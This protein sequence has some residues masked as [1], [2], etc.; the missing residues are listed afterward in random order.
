MSRLAT[1]EALRQELTALEAAGSIRLDTFEV[2]APA[3]AADYA[4]ASSYAPVPEWLRPL[5]DDCNGLTVRY[6]YVGGAS[7][8]EERYGLEHL[9]G[10]IN[11]LPLEEVFRD[12][13]GSVYFDGDEDAFRW[14]HPL[15]LYVDHACYALV[16]P[17]LRSALPGLCFHS[18]GD[19]LDA[20]PVEL[21]PYL[22]TLLARKGVLAFRH[23]APAEELLTDGALDLAR[24]YGQDLSRSPRAVSAKEKA[25][26]LRRA[27]AA[28]EAAGTR[29]RVEGKGNPHSSKWALHLDPE[30]A[31]FEAGLQILEQ[32]GF[33][34]EF[35][36][37]LTPGSCSWSAFLTVC[38]DA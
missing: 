8:L 18:F 38:R 31:A 15:D 33:S 26:A 30:A 2:G 5:Y 21:E 27:V 34:T 24:F 13:E 11:I 12:W 10:A 7:E 17:Q 14:V 35:F 36:R 23:E 3:T 28:L 20:E 16:M 1:L 19:S 9:G 37:T 6:T 25:Q 32:H 29:H 22:D 4:A